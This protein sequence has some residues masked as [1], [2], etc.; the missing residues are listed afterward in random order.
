MI[1]DWAICGIADGTV[2]GPGQNC[3][4]NPDK[5]GYC[6][7]IDSGDQCTQFL[8]WF[9]L[10]P[11]PNPALMPSSTVMPT[12]NPTMMT[13]TMMSTDSVTNCWGYLTFDELPLL[14]CVPLSAWAVCGIADGTVY[15]PGGNC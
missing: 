15:G 7:H 10:N 4:F 5:T 13:P 3:R 11:T 12:S 6:F 8:E 1:S 14:W 2:N 9:T